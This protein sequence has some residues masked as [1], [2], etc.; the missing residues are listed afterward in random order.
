MHQ[1]Q[2]QSLKR[3][4]C[5]GLGSLFLLVGGSQIAACSFDAQ[6]NK[7]RET[8]AENYMGAIL[9]SQ[10]AHFLEAEQFTDDLV[11]LGVNIPPETE[12]Y[13]Y[14]I[15]LSPQGQA[16]LVTAIAKIPELRS[17]T[18]VAY[19]IADAQGEFAG[20]DKALCI[21]ETPQQSPPAPPEFV[22]TGAQ[23]EVTCAADSQGVE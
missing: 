9:R 12:N 11:S 10:Q 2:S 17:F 21:S 18:G 16:A 4:A 15:E 19:A 7:A 22:Q 6:A 3:L 8:E 1:L 20:L 14:A 23:V 13:R 5:W